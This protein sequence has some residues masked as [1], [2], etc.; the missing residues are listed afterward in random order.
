MSASR[1]ELA[2]LDLGGS[3]DAWD[4]L[5]FAVAGER[6]AVEGV[7][8]RFDQAREPGLWAWALRGVPAGAEL[9]GIPCSPPPPPAPP[10][11]HAN[12]VERIDHVVVA[13]F[14]PPS[15]LR[16]ALKLCS[17]VPGRYPIP[18]SFGIPNRFNRIPV[19]GSIT[20]RCIVIRCRPP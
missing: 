16:T 8:M 2:A 1:P 6:I 11:R 7:V 14:Q 5:G 3:T 18:K 9:D 13:M 15:A 20:D 12:G 10:A 19:C 17:P 4:A